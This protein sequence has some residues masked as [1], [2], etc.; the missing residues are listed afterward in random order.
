METRYRSWRAYKIEVEYIEAARSKSNALRDAWVKAAVEHRTFK[1][2]YYGGPI[3]NEMTE[4]EVEP[5]FVVTSDEWR[6]FGCWGFCRLRNH[7]RVFNVG[8]IT[9]WFLTENE[10]N[11]NPN[12]RWKELILYYFENDLESIK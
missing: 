1:I 10:F 4:R 2:R 7:L 9:N 6:G 3:N 11:P 8:G 5:D 12:G